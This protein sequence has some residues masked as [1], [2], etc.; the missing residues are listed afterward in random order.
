MSSGIKLSMSDFAIVL[1]LCG[2]G[3]GVGKAR[4]TS[5]G[6]GCVPSRELTS[7]W[8]PMTPR[9]PRALVVTGVTRCP[10]LY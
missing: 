4:R 1:T 9:S 3:R 10:R 7:R 6:I 5:T 8:R 2:S